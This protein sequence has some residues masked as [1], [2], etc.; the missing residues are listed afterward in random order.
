M[1]LRSIRVRRYKNIRDSGEVKFQD[2]VTCLVGRNESGKS[3]IL[4]A[5][6]RLNPL[7]TGH[8][9]RF[10]A[11]RDYPRRDYTRDQDGVSATHPVTALFELDGEDLRV[12]EDR[13][14]RGCWRR[15]S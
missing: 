8:Q 5:L 10:V 6:Y 11:L 12:L 13:Y 3:A 14:G 9:E 2:G 4:Q 1:I 15:L 7:A